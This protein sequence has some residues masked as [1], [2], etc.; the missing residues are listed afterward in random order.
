MAVRFAPLAASEARQSGANLVS[1]V[2]H[3]LRAPLINVRGY[4]GELERSLKEVASLCEVPAQ[5]LEPR[6]RGRL[7]QLL[8]RELPE[9]LE[10]INSSVSRM[11]RLISGLLQLS[12]LEHRELRPEE[13][14]TGQL[15]G[16]LLKS[17]AH[18]IE[19][20][21]TTV[22]LGELPVLFCDRFSL[23]LILGNL[24]DNAL[25]YLEPRRPGLLEV[26][27]EKG[28]QGSIIHVRDNGLGIAPEQ[29]P[30]IFQLFRRVG[31]CEVPGEGMGLAYVKALVRQMQ[32]QVCC[33]SEP[34]AGSTFSVSI[35]QP[36]ARAA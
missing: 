31:P 12:R 14:Q 33:L 16:S 7:D 32:G 36:E 28:P 20:S 10:F 18:R 11:D 19:K 26:F 5:A 9:A 22:R 27:S 25:K 23:E 6:E 34:G 4:A 29:L 15:V 30:N 3:D 24:L 8:Q 17:L 1:Q 35:P 2:A 21:E 13:V